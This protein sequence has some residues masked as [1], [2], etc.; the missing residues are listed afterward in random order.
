V[1]NTGILVL[2]GDLNVLQ[3]LAMAG[4]L[5]DRANRNNIRI[6]RIVDGKKVEVKAKESTPVMAG[7]T[8]VVKRRIF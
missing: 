8:I 2:T 6:Q 7:D 3:A 1:K 4:G 5:T